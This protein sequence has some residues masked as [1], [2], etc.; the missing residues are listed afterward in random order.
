MRP[1]LIHTVSFSSTF[2]LLPNLHHAL[3]PTAVARPAF[4]PDKIW[5]NTLLYCQNVPPIAADSVCALP[6]YCRVQVAADLMLQTPTKGGKTH[7]K[8]C[9]QLSQTGVPE[10]QRRLANLAKN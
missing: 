4:S 2:H 10:T 1:R 5:Q 7:L 3:L 9:S 8:G 6:E